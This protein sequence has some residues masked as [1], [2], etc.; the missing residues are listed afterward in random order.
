MDER[1]LEDL[2]WAGEHHSQLLEKY[3]EQWVAIFNKQVV[4]SGESITDV[5]KTAQSKTGERH[6]PV[7][8]IDSASNIYAG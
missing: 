4:A 2:N 6:I 1:Y 8:F 5:R 3:R 7:Y